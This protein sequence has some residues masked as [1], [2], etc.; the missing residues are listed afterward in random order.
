MVDKTSNNQTF[1]INS[2]YETQNEYSNNFNSINQ[3]VSNERKPSYTHDVINTSNLNLNTSKNSNNQHMENQYF[4]NS[5]NNQ[6]N[7]EKKIM[8]HIPSTQ[9]VSSP[10]HKESCSIPVINNEVHNSQNAC[11]SC[12]AVKSATE[13]PNNTVSESGN[14]EKGTDQNVSI[15][16]EHLFADLTIINI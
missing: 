4:H 16:L 1:I 13:Q 9:Y 11:V 10:I 6:S 5:Q 14:N 8:S 3:P 7:V 15:L 12:P 2:S